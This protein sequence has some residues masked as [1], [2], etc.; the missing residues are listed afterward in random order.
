MYLREIY[1]IRHG[2]TDYN[3]KGI[4]QGAGVDAPLNEKGMKQAEAFFDAYR[5]FSFDK[6]YTSRL[7]R[8]YQTIEPFKGLDIPVEKHHG[9]NE[10][11]WGDF[12][13]RPVA[14]EQRNYYLSLLQSWREGY[15]HIPIKGGESPNDVYQ[16]QK[17][18]AEKLLNFDN[19]QTILVCMHGRAMRV[20]LCL[21]LGKCLTE[22]DEFKHAN[23][24]LYKIGVKPDNEI[25]LLKRNC[26]DHLKAAEHQF[27][28]DA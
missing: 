4:V 5:R 7:K 18:V 21:L 28:V 12:E 15:T 20:F 1:L 11:D 19:H 25:T 2:E 16:R 9:L 22:M 24:G 8:A 10:I 6:I 14:H 27:T 23:L 17:P 3:K 13:G 26:T